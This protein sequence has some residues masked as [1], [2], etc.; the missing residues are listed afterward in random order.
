MKVPFVL[1]ADRN[2]RLIWTKLVL[3]QTNQIRC[4]SAV[5]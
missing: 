4:L 5:E 1:A 3:F 2:F